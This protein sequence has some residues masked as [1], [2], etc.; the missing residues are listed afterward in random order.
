LRTLSDSQNLSTFTNQETPSD[1]VSEIA[2]WTTPAEA[3]MYENLAELY[4]VIKA[5]EILET[6]F[7]RDAITPEAYFSCGFQTSQL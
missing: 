1:N 7:T 3:E 5:T 4:A 6:L 2:L